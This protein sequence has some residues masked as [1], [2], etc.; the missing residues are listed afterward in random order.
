MGSVDGLP[1]RLG[2]QLEHQPTGLHHD[3][4]GEVIVFL[5]GRPPCRICSVAKPTH[6]DH[7]T[8]TIPGVGYQGSVVQLK[9]L[10][11]FQD[12]V[13]VADLPVSGQRLTIPG[14]D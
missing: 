7:A 5:E 3:Q 14:Y 2:L 8:L 1:E 12:T 4:R 11:P 9:E 13:S 10:L 6:Q